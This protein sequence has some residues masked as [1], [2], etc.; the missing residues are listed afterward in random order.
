MDGWILYDGACG[1]CG[2]WVPAWTSALARVG[3]GTVPLQDDA[4]RARTGLDEEALLADITL[5]F[6]DGRVVRGAD[7]YRTVMRRIWWTRGVYLLTIVPGL[8][9][10]FD[11]AYRTFARRRYEVSRL[12]R[13]EPRPG[14]RS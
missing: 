14:R 3:L 5:L 13:I 7:V 8:R 6:D 4:A 2:R 12:C 10:L 9:W 11:A 1:V